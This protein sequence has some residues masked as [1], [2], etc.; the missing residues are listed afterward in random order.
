METE[1]ENLTATEVKIMEVKAALC[2]YKEATF[3]LDRLLDARAKVV[4]RAEYKGM[5]FEP[6][7]KSR[8]SNQDKIASAVASIAELDQKIKEAAKELL[9]CYSQVSALIDNDRIPTS[10]QLILVY[11]YRNCLSWD[12]I[13]QKTGQDK[14]HCTRLHGYA[15][16]ILAGID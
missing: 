11:R 12:A 3:R 7:A 15:I 4:A 1:S 2:A 6:I 14:R 16:A 5:S 10:Q 9:P 8:K 13:A